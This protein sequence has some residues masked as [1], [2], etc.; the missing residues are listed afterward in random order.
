MPAHERFYK[1]KATES[2]E[3]FASKSGVFSSVVM[4]HLKS[5][6]AYHRNSDKNVGYIKTSSG[7]I[8]TF[9]PFSQVSPILPSHVAAPRTRPK[10]KSPPQDDSVP[11]S[12]NHLKIK[13]HNPMSQ[14]RRNESHISQFFS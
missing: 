13:L 2:E 4:P 7:S 5:D 6:N 8:I 12:G 11:Y 9:V 10:I 3:Q 1:D 14:I